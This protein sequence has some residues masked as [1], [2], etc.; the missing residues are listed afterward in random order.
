[1]QM[2]IL[3]PQARGY[4]VQAEPVAGVGIAGHLHPGAG[5]GQAVRA[6]RERSRIAG[7]GFL[8]Q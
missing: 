8:K 5:V 6:V 4:L 1:M 2:H 3:A 7:A